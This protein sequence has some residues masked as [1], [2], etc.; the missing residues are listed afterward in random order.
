MAMYIYC[1]LGE[2][3]EKITIIVHR[4]KVR[5]LSYRRSFSHLATIQKIVTFIYVP[6]RVDNE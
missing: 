2:E 1:K 6:T 5:Y 4:I 3:T